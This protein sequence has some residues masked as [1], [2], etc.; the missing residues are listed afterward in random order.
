MSFSLMSV[1]D[2]WEES[3][4]IMNNNITCDALEIV[5]HVFNERGSSVFF[6]VKKLLW[7]SNQFCIFNLLSWLFFFKFKEVQFESFV[8]LSA[9]IKP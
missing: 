4:I 7:S 3:T 1:S 6:G 2:A 5:I 9:L 8:K